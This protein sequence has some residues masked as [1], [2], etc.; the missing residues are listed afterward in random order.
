MARNVNN[1]LL[2]LTVCGAKKKCSELYHDFSES[3]FC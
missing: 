1:I 3:I 2:A